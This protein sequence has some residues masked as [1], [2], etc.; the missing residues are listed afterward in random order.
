MEKKTETIISAVNPIKFLNSKPVYVG[1]RP[2]YGYHQPR[3][4]GF[5]VVG[6]GFGV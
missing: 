3:G 6:L 4:S 5:R 2:V 1:A